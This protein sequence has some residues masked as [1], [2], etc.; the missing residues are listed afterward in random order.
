[1]WNPMAKS[2]ARHGAGNGI[3][4]NRLP[5][6]ATPCALSDGLRAGMRRRP[7]IWPRNRERCGDER[8]EMFGR[9]IGTSWKGQALVGHVAAGMRT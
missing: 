1:M 3:G 7:P 5:R 8:P 2:V 4:S 9:A 6:G